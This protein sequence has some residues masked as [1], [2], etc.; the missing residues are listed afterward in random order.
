MRLVAFGLLI[1]AA[2]RTAAPPPAAR[3]PVA[4]PAPAPGPAP[5]TLLI[6]DD[7]LA[8]DRAFA[9]GTAYYWL[10]EDAGAFT[11]QRWVFDKGQLARQYREDEILVELSY[12]IQRDGA[13]IDVYGPS[14]RA[15]EHPPDRSASE[16][17]A[18][19]VQEYGVT[20]IRDGLLLV[21]FHED[22][23]EIWF[24]QEAACQAAAGAGR[25]ARV[26]VPMAH[27]GC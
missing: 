5:V 1:V 20:P 4:A 13:A 12:T 24:T 10:V 9:D 7:L 6:D 16:G 11:C 23:Q 18:G 14:Q 17:V 25:I 27:G 26:V 22:R 8:I 19:C 2:C 15:L 21:S 3:P